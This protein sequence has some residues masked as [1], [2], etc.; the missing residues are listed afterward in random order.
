MDETQGTSEAADKA[1]A[2]MRVLRD[3][4][5]ALGRS[6]DESIRFRPYTALAMAAILGLALGGM[7]RR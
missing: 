2:S 6:L 4:T 3:T 7:W 5:S 1:D